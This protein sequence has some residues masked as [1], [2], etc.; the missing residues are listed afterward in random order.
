[1]WAERFTIYGLKE[2]IGW[3][4]RGVCSDSLGSIRG[5]LLRLLAAGHVTVHEYTE[6]GVTKKQYTITPVGRTALTDWLR[7]PPTIGHGKIDE[8][9]RQFALGIL[10][11]HERIAALEGIV[12]GYDQYLAYLT[13]ARAEVQPDNDVSI[14][15]GL[16]AD[17]PTFAAELAGPGDE[18]TH[19][20][21]AE[22]YGRYSVATLDLG[23]RQAELKRDWYQ[24]MLDHERTTT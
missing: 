18:R 13:G 17:D 2:L 24:Q 15:L 23:I 22:D 7:E 3:A 8:F 1:M 21:L 9:G 12:A 10:P 6:G 11:R 14:Y 16:W 4:L 5:A 19:R 20:E